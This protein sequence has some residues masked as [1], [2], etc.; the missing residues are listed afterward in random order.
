[1]TGAL[2]L[3]VIPVFSAV[4]VQNFMKYDVVVEN[5]P[6]VKL[7]GAD[8]NTTDFLQVDLGQTVTNDD[9]NLGTPGTN[10]TLLSNEVIT[11]ACFAGD[12]TY[13]QDVIQLQNTTAAEDWDVN[14]ILEADLAGS[15]A[16]EDTFGTGTDTDGDADIWLFVSEGDTATTA[17]T[18]RPNPGLYGTL[19]DWFDGD[20]GDAGVEAIQL[21]VVNADLAATSVTQTGSFTISGG[22]QRQI[23]LVVDCGSNMADEVGTGNTGTFRVTLEATKA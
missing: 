1:M 17:V 5:P 14:L 13:Y 10:P 9:D 3:C 19:T 15:P 6:I 2:S 22:E 7:A 18:Q 20:A 16:V 11:F 8:A 23:G 4:I 12:R 21:E